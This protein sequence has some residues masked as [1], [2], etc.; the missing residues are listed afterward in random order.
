MYPYT[1]MRFDPTITVG[2]ILTAF[3]VLVLAIMGW[4]DHNWRIKNLE[5]WKITHEH[6]AEQRDSIILMLRD[7]VT[8]LTAIAKGQDRRLVLVEDR[9]IRM[10]RPQ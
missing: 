9:V 6:T 10:D 4:R 8:T 7:N 3:P 2:N 5:V 1:L